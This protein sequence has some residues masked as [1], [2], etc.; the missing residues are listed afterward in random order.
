MAKRDYYEVLGVSKGSSAEEIKKAYRKIALKYHPDR[1]PDNTEAEDK[2]KEAAEAYEVLSDQDKRA[3][4]DRF[5]HAGMRGG[6]GG[7]H[8]DME[9]LL[10]NFENIFGFGDVFG[11]GGRGGGGGQRRR[12]TGQ[13]GNNLRIRVKLS[14][15]DIAKGS[16]KKV[17]VK[18][19]LVCEG[20][21]G[22]GAKDA[23]SYSTCS[24]CAG[25]GYV[26][27]VTHT[28]LGQMQTTGTCPTCNGS[29]RSISSHCTVCR[30]E[31]RA[32]GEET[33]TIDIPAGVSEEV[34]LSMSGKGNAGMRGGPAGDLLI[35]IEELPHESL[36]R[37]G[38][39][40]VYTLYINFADAVLGTNIEVPT[41]A[42]KA[43]IKVPPGTQSGKIFRLRGKGLPA[44]NSYGTGDQLI[45]VN[46]WTPKNLSSEEK[47][48][49]E[50]LRNMSNFQPTPGKNDKNFFDKMRDYFS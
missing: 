35:S 10:R 32:Y 13:R 26:R 1:N 14:L 42:A 33:I 38:K 2:F 49:I 23:S 16:Q 30:G 18:K 8:V 22:T 39:D 50:K 12:G 29:G 44:L 25:Q 40:V 41:I 5:G 37:E 46:I 21:R 20:C 19:H 3:R 27:R 24:T 28:F 45:E 36:K 9:D 4:Y 7:A 31:G 6:S 43:K 15:E 47:A 34:Q 48:L 11:G 17:K